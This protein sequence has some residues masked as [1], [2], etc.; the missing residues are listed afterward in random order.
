MAVVTKT[1]LPHT[2]GLELAM[3]GIGVFHL[4]FLPDAMSHSVTARCPSPFP[5]AASPRKAGQFRG[6]DRFDESARGAG[7]TGTADA[8]VLA[9][10]A[11]GAAALA[12]TRTSVSVAGP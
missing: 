8:V 1:R 3:P 6:P 9:E 12:G 11:A 10:A 7:P 4:M 5:S 2:I